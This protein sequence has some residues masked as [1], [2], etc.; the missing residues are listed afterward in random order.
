MTQPRSL[1][2]QAVLTRTFGSLK[3]AVPRRLHLAAGS[4]YRHRACHCDPFA[5]RNRLEAFRQLIEMRKIMPSTGYSST[6]SDMVP[7][8]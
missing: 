7:R 1:F 5:D 2:D 8:V 4:R 6:V 3:I